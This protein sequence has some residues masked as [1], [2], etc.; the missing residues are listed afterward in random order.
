MRRIGPYAA[1]VESGV[2]F[3]V[4][5]ANVRYRVAARFDDELEVHV[6]LEP[7]ATARSRA[8]SRCAAATSC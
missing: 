6:T 7:P 4:A 5:E 2:E 3:V 1:I 8:A